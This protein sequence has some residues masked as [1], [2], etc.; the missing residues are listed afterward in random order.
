MVPNPNLTLTYM[1]TYTAVLI[2]ANRLDIPVT[3]NSD[4]GVLDILSRHV[5]FLSSTFAE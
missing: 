1:Y 4:S 3:G 2:F 5:A